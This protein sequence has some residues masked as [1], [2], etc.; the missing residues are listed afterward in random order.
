VDS[1]Y[2]LYAEPSWL[3]WTGDSELSMSSITFFANERDT[4]LDTHAL[5]SEAR[6]S[7]FCS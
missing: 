7:M 4:A 1:K 5:L 3:P 6:A 2:P